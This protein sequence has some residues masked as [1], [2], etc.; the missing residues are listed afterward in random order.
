M[1]T[2]F[3]WVIVGVL[4]LALVVLLIGGAGGGDVPA[5]QAANT[6][7]SGLIVS[8]SCN[9]HMEQLQPEKPKRELNLLEA[10][11]AFV[12]LAVAAFG[13]GAFLTRDNMYS[14]MEKAF[15]S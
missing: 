6:R 8:N 1:K 7:C 10:A 14:E 3:P 13:V 5:G 15:N 9:V 4:V 11:A 2:V 12:L